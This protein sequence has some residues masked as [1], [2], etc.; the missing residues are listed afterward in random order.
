MNILKLLSIL[1]VLLLTNL[2]FA[3]P[4]PASVNCIKKGGALKMVD[5]FGICQ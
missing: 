5:N 2:S 4:N 3:L 1:S